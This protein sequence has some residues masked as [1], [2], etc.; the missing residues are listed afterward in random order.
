VQYKN[1]LAMIFNEIKCHVNTSLGLVGGCIPCIHSRVRACCL[2][3]N[4]AK[5]DN[6]QR[7]QSEQ[8]FEAAHNLFV[9]FGAILVDKCVKVAKNVDTPSMHQCQIYAPHSLATHLTF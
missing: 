7:V 5:G 9:Y 6:A 1:I 3:L 8:L 2:H 4:Y